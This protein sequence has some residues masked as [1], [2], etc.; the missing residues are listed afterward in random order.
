MIKNTK[1][2][3]QTQYFFTLKSLILWYNNHY[4]IV[5]LITE[6][7]NEYECVL[8]LIKLFNILI[9]NRRYLNIFYKDNK[10]VN[11]FITN[12]NCLPIKKK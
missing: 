5:F 9:I 12:K 1:I 7:Y 11:M 8:F 10:R 6:L 3:T 4:V 2:S